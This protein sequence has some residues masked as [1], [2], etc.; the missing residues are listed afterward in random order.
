MYTN[1][2]DVW[3]AGVVGV[4]YSYGF[5][6]RDLKKMSDHKAWVNAVAWRAK[7]KASVLAV[8][9]TP[10]LDVM[11]TG[12]PTARGILEGLQG[13]R[14]SEASGLREGDQAR[15]KGRERRKRRMQ[16]SLSKTIAKIVE[17]PPRF[18]LL[19]TG[20]ERRTEKCFQ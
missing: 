10:M 6:G 5:G 13:W 17:K 18:V 16:Q 14:D 7:S 12:R 9:L 11:P 4:Q 15:S 19:E 8:Y 2:V 3:S 20:T 1:A